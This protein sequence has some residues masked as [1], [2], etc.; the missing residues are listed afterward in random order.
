MTKPAKVAVIPS[1]FSGRSNE[2][3]FKYLQNFELAAVSNLWTDDLRLT[4]LPNY[5]TDTALLW[6][7]GYVKDRNAAATALA[8]A[9]CTAK[10]T[11]D[12]LRTDLQKG[13]RT[14]ASKEVA[15]EKL[16]ARKQKVGESPEDYVYSKLDL[17]HDFEHSMPLDQKIRHIIK[18]LRPS[19][20]ERI[21][22][23]NPQTIEE[24]II[25]IR[26]IAETQFMI[27]QNIE[28]NVATVNPSDDL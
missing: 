6:Y 2:D 26:K 4:G 19:Y 14:V 18:G 7:H 21:H 27:A 22:V 11:W 1:K 17:L 20:L 5:L 13:F 8:G 24:V 9:P 3:P 10:I 15:E 28:A 16:Q 25:A 23:M 12:E